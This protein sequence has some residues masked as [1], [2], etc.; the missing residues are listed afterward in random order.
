MY[1]DRWHIFNYFFVRQPDVTELCTLFNRSRTWFYK[2]KRRYEL[3][4]KV[5]AELYLLHKTLVA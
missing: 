1:E 2:W 5:P 4:G 3:Y